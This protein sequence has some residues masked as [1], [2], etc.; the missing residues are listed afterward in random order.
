MRRALDIVL[1]ASGLVLL[2]PLF[3][4][5]AAVLRREGPGPIL[6]RQ[7]RVGRDFRR[8]RILKFRTMVPDAEALGP[9]ITPAG[10]PRVTPVGAILRAT[11]LDELPQ[12]WNVLRGD[13]SLVGPRPPRS[14]HARLFADDYRA[15]L[16]VR[17]GMIDPAVLAK[18][19]GAWRIDPDADAETAYLVSI[20]PGRIRLARILALRGD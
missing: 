18:P 4:V 8:F 7:V 11:M 5:I 13:M 3:L 16:R 17:P 15:I 2:A 6:F 10:D 19:E 20:L 9:A 1:S 14:R 12:L